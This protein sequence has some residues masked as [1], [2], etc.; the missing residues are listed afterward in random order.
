MIESC[1]N[2]DQKGLRERLII[3]IELFKQVLILIK[4]T[5]SMNLFVAKKKKIFD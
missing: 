5:K 3:P 4:N 1:R 2:L